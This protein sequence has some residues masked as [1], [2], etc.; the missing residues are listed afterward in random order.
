MSLDAS[1]P[2]V[3]RQ[4]RLVDQ[5]TEQLRDLII[6]QQLPPGSLL[7]QDSLAAQLGVSRTPLRE[8]FRVLER[9]GLVRTVGSSNTI[10]VVHITEQDVRELYQIRE[11]LD[12]LVA[13]LVVA[14]G[15]DDE[16]YANLKKHA[17]SMR[18]A[19]SPVDARTFIHAHVEFHLGLVRATN[20]ARLY[21]LEWLFRLSTQMLYE[22]LASNPKRMKSSAREHEELLELVR[23]GDER[24]AEDSARAHIRNA[25]D[26]WQK[27]YAGRPE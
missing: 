3:S 18:R 24:A 21:Q 13:R 22:D 12:G 8:A 7:K 9:E 17:V 25:F 2:I 5:I 20:N 1:I 16:H 11:V 27:H 10:E 14:N 26:T 19:T 15:L 6:S 23:R 4:P